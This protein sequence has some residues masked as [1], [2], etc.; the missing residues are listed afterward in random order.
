MA[1]VVPITGPAA[2]LAMMIS[3][4]ITRAGNTAE[5]RGSMGT[6]S[7]VIVPVPSAFRPPSWRKTTRLVPV[8]VLVGVRVSLAIVPSALV[9]AAFCRLTA[10]T[11]SKSPPTFHRRKITVSQTPPPATTWGAPAPV[12]FALKKRESKLM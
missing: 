2:S 5:A 6:R 1:V 8:A 12:A 9:P 11:V 7:L 4:V 3:S 10:S